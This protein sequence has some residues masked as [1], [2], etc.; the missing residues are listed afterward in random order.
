MFDGIFELFAQVLS[1]FYDLVPN[2][3]IAIA[4]LTLARDGDH[5]ALHAQGHPQHDPDAAAPAR[6]EASS[7]SSTRTTARS[8]TKS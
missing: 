7:R 6:D 8:S 1:F 3:A 5:H 4:L 2:Y